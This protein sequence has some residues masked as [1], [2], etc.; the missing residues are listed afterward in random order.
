[1]GF[2][3]YSRRW[4]LFIVRYHAI[5]G[6]A[7]DFDFF[8]VA[9][10]DDAQRHFAQRRLPFR[11][12][13]LPGVC[14]QSRIKGHLHQSLNARQSSCFCRCFRWAPEAATSSPP[15]WSSR[16]VSRNSAA[17]WHIATPHRTA[18]CALFLAG[19]RWYAFW[20]ADD[21]RRRTCVY[22]ARHTHAR[23]AGR[24]SAGSPMVGNELLNREILSADTQL[25][26]HL[27]WSSC[28][29]WAANLCEAI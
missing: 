3:R 15:K 8:L 13:Y 12:N 14:Q 17:R 6:D 25:R 23:G 10:V 16:R 7:F 27:I 9:P 11:N 19:H 18:P 5:S 21:M 28:A 1:M 20:R 22:A 4:F 2:T 29:S 24:R 26:Y